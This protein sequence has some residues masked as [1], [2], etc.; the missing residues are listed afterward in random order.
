MGLPAAAFWVLTA[1]AKCMGHKAV[2]T[3]DTPGFLVNHAGRGLGS[4]GL[5]IVSEGIASFAEVDDILRDGAGFRMGPFELMDLTG[6]DIGYF[7]KQARYAETGDPKDAPSR[8]VTEL[9]EHGHLGRKSGR[10]WYVYDE[11]GNKT[12][13][14]G[15]T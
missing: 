9:V 15:G 7:T 4:E 2:R 5:R 1:L 14:A 10:G 11:Q 6:I 3:K 12:T 8:S 13:T